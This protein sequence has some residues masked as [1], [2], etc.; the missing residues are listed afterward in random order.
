[1]ASFQQREDFIFRPLTFCSGDKSY[2]FLGSDP[3]SYSRAREIVLSAFDAI[4]LPKEDY[5][6]HS[7]KPRPN[8]DES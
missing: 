4:G 8:E 6:L 5:G 7:L 1:M 2:K 3:L